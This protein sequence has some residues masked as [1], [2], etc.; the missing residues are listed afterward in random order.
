MGVATVAAATGAPTTSASAEPQQVS[1]C[2]C[3]KRVR[4]VVRADD[5]IEWVRPDVMKMVLYFNW[6]SNAETE[7]HESWEP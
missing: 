3:Y 4:P 7:A 6:S 5:T 1:R 2:T